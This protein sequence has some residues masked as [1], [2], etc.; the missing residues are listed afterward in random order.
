MNQQRITNHAVSHHPCRN[1]DI[2]NNTEQQ[3][4]WVSESELNVFI[5]LSQTIELTAADIH[6]AGIGSGSSS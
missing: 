6:K 1:T 5:M 4:G 3:T 2:D